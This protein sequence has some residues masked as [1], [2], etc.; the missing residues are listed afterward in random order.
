MSIICIDVDYQVNCIEK[1]LSNYDN[2]FIYIEYKKIDNFNCSHIFT[3][4]YEINGIT[5]YVDLFIVSGENE[6][7]KEKIDLIFELCDL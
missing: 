2:S 6:I 4:S 7:V 3:A 1:F 5:L